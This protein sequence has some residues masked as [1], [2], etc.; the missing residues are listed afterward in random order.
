MRNITKLI[1]IIAAVLLSTN[2]FAQNAKIAHID[3]QGLLASLP[4]TKQAEKDLK[5]YAENLQKDLK[6]LEEEFTAKFKIYQAKANDMTK[7]TRQTKEEELQSAKERVQSF[8]QRAT[9]DVKAKEIELV[10]PIV[11]K[12]KDAI[13]AVGKEKGYTYVID[14]SQGILVYTGSKAIDISPLVKAK[15]GVK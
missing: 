14:S 3:S 12:I 2:T 9:Q 11:K 8:Q 7:L 1:V 10:Q 13:E 5:A 6:M 4:E 15:L